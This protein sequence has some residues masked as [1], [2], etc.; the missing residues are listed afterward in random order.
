M[1][2]FKQKQKNETFSFL[3]MSILIPAIIVSIVSVYVCFS[4][5]SKLTAITN[6]NTVSNMQSA[7]AYCENN[8]DMLKSTV[9]F[10]VHQPI[11]DRFIEGN[12][13]IQSPD[14][15]ASLAQ[16]SAET[17]HVIT[18]F[19]LDQTNGVVY[20]SGGS[21][22]IPEYF[23]DDLTYSAYDANYWQS[24]YIYTNNNFRMLSPCAMHAGD[25][26]YN[27][28]PIVYKVNQ[29]RY[30]V[31]NVDLTTIISLNNYNYNNSTQYFILNNFTEEFFSLNND[32]DTKITQSDNFANTVLSRPNSNFKT[33][34]A[35]DRYLVSTGTANRSL[36]G[37]TYV[38]LT[39]T[40][41]I[42]KDILLFIVLI[43]A[44]CI[45]AISSAV[46]IAFRN[47]KNIFKPISEI[48]SSLKGEDSIASNMLYDNVSLAQ[49][50]KSQIDL[51]QKSLPYAQQKYLINVLNDL[52]IYNKDSDFDAIEGSFSFEY[53][54]F[55]IVILQL[56]PAPNFY[57]KFD[58]QSY[59]TIKSGFYNVVCDMFTEKF[60][61]YVL[62][63]ENNVLNIIL[64]F[65]DE[66]QHEEIKDVLNSIMYFL[67]N[68]FEYITV[69]IGMSKAYR[70]IPGLK[71][72]HAEALDSFIPYHTPNETPVIDISS[73]D[74]FIFTITD[75]TTVY[76]ALS[77]L[78]KDT[79]LAAINDILSDKP[80]LSPRDTKRMYNYILNT[81]LKYMRIN[82]IPYMEDMLDFEIANKFLAQ[83][84]SGVRS[85]IEE[86]V[87]YL[88]SSERTV[89]DFDKLYA[90][91]KAN[92]SSQD[93]SLKQLA[94]MFGTSQSTVTRLIQSNTD[95]SFKQLLNNLRIDRA[96][97]L[98]ETTELTIEQ[99]L[100]MVGFTN[101]QTFH[102]VFKS[103]TGM[104]PADYRKKRID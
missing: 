59:I 3:L 9:K 48:Y 22:P 7:S 77:T 30:F 18:T 34:L 55:S 70:G 71:Q 5:F 33:V 63:A 12:D 28:I 80:T 83:P 17:P 99:I 96:K 67:T 81:I 2:F 31:L 51:L 38:A 47:T 53:D 58:N 68:D 57:D 84:L 42:Y 52:E 90:Y 43:I 98:L 1:R 15:F 69:S 40:S 64:N 46:F 103:V 25:K 66:K 95:Y 61:T 97:D 101:K 72:A 24:L 27:T 86:L 87:D 89:T 45:I 75:E 85:Y 65:K 102:R 23:S 91:I 94:D 39:P 56:S 6:K 44:V 10:Y 54:L 88:T 76:S 35:R 36:L 13:V 82:K 100:E 73:K 62:P 104:T 49:K 20:H 14:F 60:R 50:A 78:D 4:S 19:L 41:E 8:I 11:T 74:S 32:N 29:K 26:T 92:C 37:Y 16:F 93:M 21:V 79:I